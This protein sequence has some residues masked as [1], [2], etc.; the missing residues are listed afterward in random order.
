MHIVPHFH[1]NL[2]LFFTYIGLPV[3]TLSFLY[4]CSKVPSFFF[5]TVRLF[6]CQFLD[7][8]SLCN[9]H[10]LPPPS[11]SFPSPSFLLPH[12]PFSPL[13][14]LPPFH[15]C[16]TPTLPTRR[17]IAICHRLHTDFFCIKYCTFVLRSHSCFCPF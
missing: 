13:L 2:L 12:F 11:T 8:S 15:S 6:F 3:S 5:F 16:F 1:F 14:R 4:S 17:N 7:T 10:F 9:F